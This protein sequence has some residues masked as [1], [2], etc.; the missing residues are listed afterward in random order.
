MHLSGLHGGQAVWIRALNMSGIVA[1]V[2]KTV[3]G[4][5]TTELLSDIK[6]AAFSLLHVQS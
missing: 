2:S 5:V 4:H 3:T 1:R 6:S